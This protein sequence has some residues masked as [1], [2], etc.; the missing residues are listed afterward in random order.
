[1]SI[2][3]VKVI[4]LCIK[5]TKFVI[6]LKSQPHKSVSLLPNAFLVLVAQDTSQVLK[7]QQFLANFLEFPSFFWD[8]KYII[9]VIRAPFNGALVQCVDAF[10]LFSYS[11]GYFL[12]SVHLKTLEW[13]KFIWIIFYVLNMF[14]VRMYTLFNIF[15]QIFPFSSWIA[16]WLMGFIGSLQLNV[17]FD[18]KSKLLIFL[19]R[20]KNYILCKSFFQLTLWSPQI[21]FFLI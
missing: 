8:W 16:A 1:M 13:K 20:V 15:V 21:F 2:R 17:T 3:V 18:L 10:P 5:N 7:H 12:Q 19:I 14:L 6:S 9:R 4:H 11:D